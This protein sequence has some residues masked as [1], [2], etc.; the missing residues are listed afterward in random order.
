M[1]IEVD[2]E[3]RL[4]SQDPGKVGG[5]GEPELVPSE[6]GAAREQRIEPRELCIESLSGVLVPSSERV[7]RAAELVEALEEE[8]AGGA[9]G[10]IGRPE[11]GSG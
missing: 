7:V 11:G 1:R 9:L 10:R 3:H 5:I 2:A 8:A 6:E 4:G